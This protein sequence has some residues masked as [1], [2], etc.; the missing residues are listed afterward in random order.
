M[1]NENNDDHNTYRVQYHG[2]QNFSQGYVAKTPYLIEKASIAPH[3]TG[4]GVFLVEESFRCSPPHWDL[5]SLRDI[6]V[7]ISQVP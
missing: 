1:W 4:S 3:I 2:I 6:V 7:L 5:A